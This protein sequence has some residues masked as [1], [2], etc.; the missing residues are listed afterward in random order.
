MAEPLDLAQQLLEKGDVLLIQL[1]NELFVH[2]LLL[3]EFVQGAKQV[4]YDQQ[5][6]VQLVHTALNS[7]VLQKLSTELYDVVSLEER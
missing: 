3:L 4:V 1:R 7:S 5:L 6:V 2:V